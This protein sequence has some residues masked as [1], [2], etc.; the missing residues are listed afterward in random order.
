MP[1]R[2]FGTGHNGVTPVEKVDQTTR[3]NDLYFAQAIGF[4]TLTANAV[5]GVSPGWNRT[6]SVASVANI[7]VGDW[8]IVVDSTL[9]DP[10]FATMEVESIDGLE[11]T[12]TVLIPFIFPA[13]SNVVSTT[14][15]L[16]VDGSVTPQIFQ[17][18]SG[19]AFEIDITR[20]LT[21]CLTD[22]AV[23]LSTFGDIA[24]GLA[25]PMYLRAKENGWYDNKAQIK[26][27]FDFALYGYD[28][29]PY[30]KTNP[31]Q[32]QDGFKWRFSL[33]GDDKHGAVQRVIGSTN[34]LE[35]VVQSDL[36]SIVKLLSVGAIHEVD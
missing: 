21:A 11:V 7:S 25:R 27:N 30:A 31:V 35:W 17:I 6:L 3:W 16:N 4:T 9:G 32:G 23:D 2:S 1:W 13:G 8:V 33:N 19:G 18:Q 5:I 12:F 20:T 36:T 10:R 34:T 28:W 14:R 22:T 24:G 26:L 15:D 29:T